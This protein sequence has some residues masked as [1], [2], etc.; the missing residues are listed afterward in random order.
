MKELKPYIYHSLKLSDDKKYIISCIYINGHE[1]QLKARTES[2]SKIGDGLDAVE[3]CGI[4]ID[5]EDK[6]MILIDY[7]TVSMVNSEATKE[8]A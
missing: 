1:Y 3:G 5:I 2:G 4:M 6:H 7:E 8:L